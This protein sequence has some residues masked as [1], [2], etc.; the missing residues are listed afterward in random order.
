MTP[1]SSVVKYLHEFQHAIFLQAK[2]DFWKAKY[3]HGA[4]K[5]A[6]AAAIAAK[7]TARK[8]KKK[9]TASDLFKL[10]DIAESEVALDSL[11]QFFNN[12]I[13]TDYCQDDTGASQAVE[14]EVT[15]SSDSEPLPRQKPRLVTRKV[16]FSHP[17]AYLDPH[18]L[19]KKQQ[20]ESRRQTR[21][22]DDNELPSGLPKTPWKRQN[23]VSFTFD[24]CFCQ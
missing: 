8:S 1:F 20:H 19:L 16:R 6:R 23:E 7:K 12:L 22:S 17:L 18:F 15:I 11:G 10:D 5:K 3:D 14:E 24:F 21:T 2:S 9:T 4:A 13:D